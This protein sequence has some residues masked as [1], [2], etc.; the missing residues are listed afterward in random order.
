MA[1]RPPRFARQVLAL[2]VG[3]VALVTGVGFVLAA[4]LL[5]RSLV[6]QYGQRALG[7]ARAV[8]ADPDLA[9]ATAAGDP[10][11]LVRDRAQRVRQATGALF[12]VVAD[13]GGIRLS[14]P[15]PEQIGEPVSTDPAALAG[16]EV[17]DVQRGTLGPS[18][19]GK[20]PLREPGGRIVGQVSVGFDAQDI[21]TAFLR[22]LG[23]SAALTGGALLVGIAGSALLVRLLKRRTLG[24]EPHE[25]AELLRQ[26]EAVLHGIGEGVLAVA[27]GRISLANGEAARLLGPAASPG[28]PLDDLDLPPR[29]REAIT[30]RQP[31]DHVIAVVGPRV[32]VA[33]HRVVRRGGAD[34]GS[35][36]TLRDRTDLE[37][38]SR[39]LEAVRGTTDVLR[40]QRHEFSN[41]L[42]VLSGLL[43]TG[44]HQ[45][46]VDY[47]H[48][49]STGTVAGLGPA[50]DA[51][52]DPYLASFL[53]AKKAGALE[54]GVELVLGETSWVE[55]PVAAPVEVLTVLGNL[56]DNA[57]EAAQVG[58]RRPAR[59]EVDLLSEGTALH[60][61][62]LDSGDGVPERA[63]DEVFAQGISTKGG[64][65]G[66]G[67]ALAR[68]SAR[69]LGGD[70][71]LAD[72]G[73]TTG[74]ALFVARLPEA[75]EFPSDAEGVA[76]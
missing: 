57:C 55:T 75:L 52:R 7:V 11:G 54:R 23:T 15:D 59:V 56:V 18:A 6:E 19:R 60:V 26:R 12:I 27:A 36:L 33:N 1:R 51:V 14:H 71:R 48:A 5:D 45:E 39:E 76:R 24:L 29:L 20:V 28:A 2:Q 61:S 58:A 68:Q 10:A 37:A 25:L 50:A 65:R 49:L 66:M 69:S 35:V 9:R 21:D 47:L 13:R 16:R 70:L 8:A 43:Q 63:R 44:H 34:L 31:L 40:A 67:L 30:A 53:A 32:L 73:G 4:T 42:H 41:R 62:V 64:E 38:L 46:A 3:L 17:V 22:L 74:G 72:P